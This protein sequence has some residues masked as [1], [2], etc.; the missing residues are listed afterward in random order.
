MIKIAPLT[1]LYQDTKSTLAGYYQD[2]FYQD[3]H[4][5]GKITG[6]CADAVSEH[7]GRTHTVMT[8]SGTDALTAMLLSVGVGCD[9]EVICINYSNP[10]SVMPIK[11]LGAI[12]VFV[13]INRYGSMDL[14]DLPITTRT[15]AVIVTGL[16][17]DSVDWDLIAD[18]EVPV[19]NDSAQCLTTKY[20]DALVTAQGDVTA[21][22]FAFNKNAPVYGT[23]GSISTDDQDLYHKLKVITANGYNNQDSVQI[24]HIGIMGKASEDK[25]AQC[26][27]SLESLPT[28]QLARRDIAEY[29]CQQFDRNG[30]HVRPSPSYSE[31]N[32]HKFCIFVNNKKQFSELMQAQGIEC[33]LHY[34]YNFSKYSVL[35]PNQNT[36]PWTDFYVDHAVSIPC[37]PWLEHNEIQQVVDAVSTINQQMGTPNDIDRLYE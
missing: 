14:T 21:L 13:D 7:T 10:A 22:S 25:S 35:N 8:T 17:G 5:N 24:S 18:V 9:D 29:Y 19:L 26:L 30:V 15:K 34:T 27:A 20:K 31:T 1:R 32:H 6:K 11:L 12:P 33:N 36:Y 16:Y 23:Y 28:W 2:V 4:V 37:H 3:E